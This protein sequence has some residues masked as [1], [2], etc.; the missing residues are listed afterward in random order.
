MPNICLQ[1]IC[2]VSSLN[3]NLSPPSHQSYLHLQVYKR[4]AGGEY[5]LKLGASRTTFGEIIKKHPSLPFSLRDLEAKNAKLGVVECVNHD[6]LQ[7]FAVLH[8]KQNALVAQFKATVLLM[9]NGSDRV[10]TAPLQDFQSEKKVRNIYLKAWRI[11]FFLETIRIARSPARS[12]HSPSNRVNSGERSQYRSDIAGLQ[13]A[14]A[15]CLC[16]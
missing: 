15:T 9:P 13:M 7:P 8:E 16:L 5:K 6:L 3:L 2:S 12:F 11:N 1:L 14:A 4:V 10:T